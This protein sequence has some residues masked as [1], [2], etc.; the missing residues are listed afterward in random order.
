MRNIR[1][2]NQKRNCKLGDDMHMITCWLDTNQCLAMQDFIFPSTNL[3]HL[4]L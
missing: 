3:N 1:F 2:I 4:I